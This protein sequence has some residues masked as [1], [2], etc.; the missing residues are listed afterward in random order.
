MYSGVRHICNTPVEKIIIKIIK[1]YFKTC[2]T[3]VRRHPATL[4]NGN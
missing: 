4:Q 2:K 3:G 1:Y